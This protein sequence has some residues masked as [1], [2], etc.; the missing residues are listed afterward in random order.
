ML[1]MKYE[2]LKADE[3]RDIYVFLNQNRRDFAQ[4][5]VGYVLSDTLTF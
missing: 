3:A 1:D 2:L 4:A 5:S